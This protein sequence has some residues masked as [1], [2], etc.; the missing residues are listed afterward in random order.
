MYKHLN[1]PYVGKKKKKKILQGV[2]AFAMFDFLFERNVYVDNN[3]LIDS[4][5]I[6]VSG[7]LLSLR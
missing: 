1:S 4:F 2:F 3:I 6:L 5:K 7:V